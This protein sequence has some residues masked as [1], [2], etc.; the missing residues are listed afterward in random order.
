MACQGDRVDFLL[1]IA[2]KNKTLK[3]IIS[4]SQ[5]LIDYP[6]IS[7]LPFRR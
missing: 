4:F 5:V 6:N 2:K 7:D 3:L 1:E